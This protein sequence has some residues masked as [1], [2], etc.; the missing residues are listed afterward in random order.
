MQLLECVL[1]VRAQE[2][3]KKKKNNLLS[4]ANYCCV[5]KATWLE[6]QSLP[7]LFQ[8]SCSSHVSE[9]TTAKILLQTSL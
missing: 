5:L 7:P 3:E 8:V 9:I 1:Q 6:G 2:G 4:S